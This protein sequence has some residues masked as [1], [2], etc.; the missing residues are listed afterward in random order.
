MSS[1]T[2][3]SFSIHGVAVSSGIA[4]GQAHLVSNALLEVVHY[5]LPKHLIETEIDRFSEAITS[6]KAELEQINHNLRKN[7]PAELSAFVGTHLMMLEDKSLTETPKEIIRNE[8]CNAEWAIKLQMDD[9]VEQFE[10]IEDVYF[11]ERKQDVVQVVE[12]IIKALLGHP[13]QLSTEQQ[14]SAV[15]QERKLI[16]VAHD[17]SPADAI[18]FKQH[19]FAA[20]ITDVG[21][22][23]SHTAILARSLNI[24]SIVALQRAHDLINDGELI[25]V[26]GHLGIVIVNPSKEILAEYKLRQDQWELEQQKLKR[27]KSTK[28]ITIDGVSIDLLA[29]IEVPEDVAAVRLAGATGIGLY[30]TEFLFMNRHDTP[31]EEEQFIAYKKVAEAMKGAPVTIRTLD[32]GADKQANADTVVNCANP[33][34]GLRAIRFCLSEP[35]VFHTQLRALL[36]ASHFGN[37]K[38]LIPMLCTLSELR[39][40]KLLLERAKQSLRKENISF[41]ENIALGGMIEI[42]AAAINAEAFANELDFLSIGTNDLIQYTLAIDRTD[43]AVAHLY[44]PLHPSILKLISMTIK[45]GAKLGKP[46]SV[47]GEMAGDARFTKL[48]LGMGL[49]QLS[50]HPSHILSIKQQV[51]HSQLAELTVQARKVLGLTDTEKIELSLAKFNQIH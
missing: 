7:A 10:K 12:R 16:L 19:Q 45:A 44:N 43:D 35:Q 31:D 50:M 5:Q 6:V 47:C 14:M 49:Q 8:Q 21:G 36:R 2:I 32:L 18:Q 34:L 26:D 27:I 20:F 22:V 39:Q 4:I 41:D 46:V 38:I 1:L 15:S 25:I 33:A 28:A 3:P 40:T 48:L 9:I 51:L 17:I 37:I 29:N 24:P 11:R 13:S 23:T 42:P 30:R